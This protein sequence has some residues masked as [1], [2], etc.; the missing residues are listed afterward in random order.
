MQKFFLA[1]AVKFC[2]KIRRREIK[3]RIGLFF[4]VYLHLETFAALKI[5]SPA[6]PRIGAA[7]LSFLLFDCF[8]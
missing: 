7:G 3:D 6:A 8:E 5:K 1:L 2:S 4:A